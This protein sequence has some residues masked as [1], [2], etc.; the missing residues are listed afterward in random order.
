MEPEDTR[1]QW[2]E[3]TYGL[4]YLCLTQNLKVYIA[5]DG[6]QRESEGGK[7]AEEAKIFETAF[8]LGVARFWRA[9]LR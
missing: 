3:S 2:S 1:P 6:K 4:V 5:V 7:A 9:V 8:R